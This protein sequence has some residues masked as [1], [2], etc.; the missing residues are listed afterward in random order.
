ME[1]ANNAPKFDINYDIFENASPQRPITSHREPL[2][3]DTVDGVLHKHNIVNFSRKRGPQDLLNIHGQ[4]GDGEAKRQRHAA[5]PEHR[6]EGLDDGPSKAEQLNMSPSRVSKFREA[7]MHDRPSEQPPSIFTRHFNNHFGTSDDELMDEYHKNNDKPLLSHPAASRSG[8][9]KSPEPKRPSSSVATFTFSEDTEDGKSAGIFKFGKSLASAFNPMAA[10]S[11]FTAS[12]R[13]AKEELIEEAEDAQKREMLERQR[14]AEQAYAELK[15]AGKL[16]AQGARKMENTPVFTP[17][18]RQPPVK[19]S[20]NPRDSAISMDSGSCT[21]VETS[22]DSFLLQSDG[23]PKKKHRH[24]RTPSFRNLKKMASEFNLQRRSA[25]MSQSPEKRDLNVSDEQPGCLR[26]S[27][28]RSNIFELLG[29]EDKLASLRGSRSRAN[30]VE[31]DVDEF[32]NLRPRKDIAKQAK[33]TKR[34][35]DLEAKLESARREL[36][37]AMGVV[38]LVPTLPNLPSNS[39][40][41]RLIPRTERRAGGERDFVP[42]LPTVLSE[43]LLIQPALIENMSH[44]VETRSFATTDPLSHSDGNSQARCKKVSKDLPLQ[45]SSGN[46]MYSQANKPLLKPDFGHS[47]PSKENSPCPP[48]YHPLPALQATAEERQAFLS[49]D[50]I[51]TESAK[52]KLS[53]KDSSTKTKRLSTGDKTYGHHVK[54][55]T[56][57]DTKWNRGCDKPN[58]LEFKGLDHPEESP[59]HSHI[60]VLESTE[61]SKI[62]TRSKKSPKVLTKTAPKNTH[63]DLPP[64]PG[65]LESRRSLDTVHEEVIF[66]NTIPAKNGSPPQPIAH[67]TPAFPRRGL[68]G[69][70]PYRMRSPHRVKKA[71]TPRR[72]RDE[73][74]SSPPPSSS[75][76]RLQGK[77]EDIIMKCPNG[78][79]VPELPRKVDSKDSFEWPDDV[80]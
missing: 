72:V 78:R 42:A 21:S 31:N 8:K 22:K 7:S 40:E 1:H 77:D 60:P 41:H 17:G 69:G 57:D 49:D 68:N 6:N 75:R 65:E 45:V 46:T 27:V 12:W 74:S 9:M 71:T 44:T 76:A 34:V 55:T 62:D 80:F 66:S 48:E 47:L 20:G 73:R 79:D 54:L 2:P 4:G 64:T 50:S 16:G 52:K 26:R 29:A 32:G 19:E 3:T 28:S 35:S 37:R 56:N 53:K 30:L 5:W 43:S 67:T 23:S 24:H 61:I 58:Q 13:N 33:L 11:K 70:S 25:S 18:Y 14:K 51:S 38:P 15:Q 10:W 36:D 39:I 59:A 63:K